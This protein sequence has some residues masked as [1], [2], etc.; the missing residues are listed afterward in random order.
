MRIYTLGFAVFTFFSLMLSITWMTGHATGFWRIVMR[1]FQDVGAAM[2][3]ANS[4]AILTD[5]FPDTQRGD[6]ARGESS[7]RVHR[8]LY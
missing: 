1:I 5:V 8:S 7:G 3:M 4:A 2:P 6:G